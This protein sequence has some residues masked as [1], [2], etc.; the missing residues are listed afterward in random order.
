MIET[1]SGSTGRARVD[2]RRIGSRFLGFFSVPQILGRTSFKGSV[3]RWDV[4]KRALQS[5]LAKNHMPWPVSSCQNPIYESPVRF[6]WLHSLTDA[7]DFVVFF[8]W[9]GNGSMWCARVDIN[10]NMK[11]SAEWSN[12]HAKVGFN[13]LDQQFEITENKCLSYLT[14]AS[15]RRFVTHCWT[16]AMLRFSC[17]G[18]FSSQ[19]HIETTT[20]AIGSTKL[21]RTF[22]QMPAFRRNFNIRCLLKL[23]SQMTS[24]RAFLPAY[25]IQTN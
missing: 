6:R 3:T 17:E 16:A 22:R 18:I 5:A 9:M 19:N 10:Q 11:S 24:R 2:H 7:P 1:L 4:T 15:L 25:W 12:C 20:I 13:S 21:W 8:D 14:I 23:A